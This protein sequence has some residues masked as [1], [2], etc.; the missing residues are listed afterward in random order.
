MPKKWAACYALATNK[1]GAEPFS[2]EHSPSVSSRSWA[3]PSAS[4]PDFRGATFPT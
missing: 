1:A 4:P 2:G 3:A